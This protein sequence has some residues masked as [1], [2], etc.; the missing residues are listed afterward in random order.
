MGIPSLPNFSK[1]RA[2]RLKRCCARVP[3]PRAYGVLYKMLQAP[4]IPRKSAPRRDLAFG[5]GRFYLVRPQYLVEKP[6]LGL[7]ISAI[8]PTFGAAHYLYFGVIFQRLNGRPLLPSIFIH[9]PRFNGF[10]E[11]PPQQQIDCARC[12][13]FLKDCAFTDSDRVM[14]QHGKPAGQ[15]RH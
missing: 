12:A 8:L 3:N 13:W 1:R 10:V 4:W 14:P 6:S 9:T 15:S 2:A 7:G 11:F 5:L